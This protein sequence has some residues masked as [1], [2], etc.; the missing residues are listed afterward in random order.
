MA[1]RKEAERVAINTQVQGSASDIMKIAMRNFRRSVYEQG[2]CS[3]DVRIIGQVHDEVI[4]EA[5][6]EYADQMS[7]LLKDSMEGAAE[8]RVPL[9][10][11]PQIANSW[12]E[13]K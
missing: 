5:K 8:L 7:Q 12:G 11:E 13:A 6:E 3:D 1:L 9:I 10:A 2:L 4:V